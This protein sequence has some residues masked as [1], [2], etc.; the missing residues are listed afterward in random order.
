MEGDVE[1]TVNPL[2]N[3][4]KRKHAAVGLGKASEVC[5]RLGEMFSSGS[6]S[7]AGYSMAGFAR[8]HVFI[9]AAVVPLRRG[10]ADRPE[11]G[12]KC[13]H[14]PRRVRDH[15]PATSGCACRS[16]IECS[17]TI[18]LFRK[19]NESIICNAREFA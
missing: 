5:W 11:A 16:N 8:S 6:V 1:S 2:K 17:I 18:G 19:F 3:T 15:N 14:N 10:N 12:D 7:L 4:Y 9:F 13:R